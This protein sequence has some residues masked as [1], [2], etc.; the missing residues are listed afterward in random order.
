MRKI[1][2]IL[3]ILISFSYSDPGDLNEDGIIDILELD[4]EI[5]SV[6]KKSDVSEQDLSDRW[7]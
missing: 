5:K 2:L 1:Y 3:I 4:M 7:G 6:E